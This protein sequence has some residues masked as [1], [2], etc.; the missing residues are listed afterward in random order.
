M[1]YEAV[2]GLEIHAE[3]NTESKMFCSSKNDPFHSEPNKNICPVCMGLPGTLPVM[4]RKALDWV[5]MSGLAMNCQIN[6]FS[7]WDRK[8]YYY[9]DLPKGYQISQYD[10]PLAY[11][12][13]LE[14]GGKKIGITRIHLEEDTGK[15]IHPKGEDYSLVDFNRSGVPLMELVTEP[16]ITTGLQAANFAQELQLILRTL[17]ISKT[18]MEKGEMRVEV[19]ISVREMGAQSFGTKVEIKNLNSFMAVEKSVDFE[20]HRQTEILQKGGKI[21]QETRGW[22]EDKRLTFSQ[23][24]KETA[25]D[26][27][28]FPEPDLPPVEISQEWLSQIKSIIPELPAERRTRY[29]N[30]GVPANYAEV[31]TSIGISGDYFDKVVRICK[32][33]NARSVANWIVQEEVNFQIKPEFFGDLMQLIDDKKINVT[34]GREV[35]KRLNSSPEKSPIKIVEEM[36]IRTLNGANELI[37]IIDRILK[38]NSQAVNDCKKGKDMAIGYLVGQVMKETRGQADSIKT[39]EIIVSKIASGRDD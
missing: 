13:F 6:K 3:L 14:V 29:K 23:R 39:R 11:K 27:R 18:N 22:N 28:Y 30:M 31:L 16:D 12:G 9:P 24:A 5:I 21:V 25:M 2:I 1:K 20:I 37:E 19:N 32:A 17:G 36:D 7:K 35:L 33:L 38:T 15:L 10:L 8:N 26:Y 34:I 4:N